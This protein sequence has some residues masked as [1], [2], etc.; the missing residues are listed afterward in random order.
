[1]QTLDHD[2]FMA[3]NFDGG[4]TFDRLM[5]LVSGTQMWLPLYALI[6]WLVWRQQGWRR[7]LLFLGLM[8]AA[9]AL[10]DMV[11][12]IFKH[13]GLLKGLLPDFAPRPRPMFTPSLEGLDITPDSLKALRRAALPRPWSVHVPPEAVSGLYGTVSAHASTIVALAVLSASVIRRRWFTYLMVFCTILICYS[14]IYLG[15]HYPIDI[16]WGSLVGL[17]LGLGAVWIYRRLA[18]KK[19][20]Q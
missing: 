2:L 17:L 16:V 8:I 10:A 4:A 19:G 9:L 1:M 12:G 14:R 11:A 6:G 3:L 13:T 15:K 5:L 20:L 7:T 18:Q